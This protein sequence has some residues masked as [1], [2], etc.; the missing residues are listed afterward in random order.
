[1]MRPFPEANS[2]AKLTLFPGLLSMRSMEGTESPA[3]TIVRGVLWKQ[4]MVAIEDIRKAEVVFVKRKEDWRRMGLI[5]V[6]I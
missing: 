2:F 6:M 5:R 1:M 3:L 4:R